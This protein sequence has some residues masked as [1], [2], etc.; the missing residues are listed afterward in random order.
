MSTQGIPLFGEWKHNSHKQDVFNRDSPLL[1]N[2]GTPRFYAKHFTIERAFDRDRWC[3]NKATNDD[4]ARCAQ[5]VKRGKQLA[6][7]DRKR[8]LQL[9]KAM[10]G[11]KSINLLPTTGMHQKLTPIK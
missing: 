1:D 9:E 3:H 10:G 2:T 5:D 6:K 11:R 8:K 4:F 7:L